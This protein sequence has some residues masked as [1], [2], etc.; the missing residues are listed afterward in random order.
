LKGEWQQFPVAVWVVPGVR[1]IFPSL[2]SL[3]LF[4]S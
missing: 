1:H 4:S 3:S 2:L